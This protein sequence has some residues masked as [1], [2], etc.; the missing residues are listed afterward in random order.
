MTP[1]E[2]AVLDNRRVRAWQQQRGVSQTTYQLFTGNTITLGGTVI[3]CGHAALRQSLP[4]AAINADGVVTQLG[5]DSYGDLTSESTPDGNGTQLATI[6]DTYDA[7]GEQ[8]S[9]TSPDGNVTGANAGNYTTVTAFDADGNVT[10]VTQAGGS[11][12]TATPRVT[13]YGYD[14]DSNQVTLDDARGYTT[15]TTYN[16]DDLPTLVTDPDSN[17]TLTCY[18]GN[19]HAAQT[20]PPAAS[21]PPASP[22]PPAPP[23]TPP[24]T[25]RPRSSPRMP[26]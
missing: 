14:A 9:E 21:P 3:S 16:A 24:D 2:R 26:P 11:G 4:C 18:D 13:G 22:P 15:T 23:P 6:T 8:T 7:D 12:A 1:R 25:W 10:S 17:Q 20:V 5:Y 19:G